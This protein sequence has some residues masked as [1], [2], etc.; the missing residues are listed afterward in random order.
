[1]RHIHTLVEVLNKII[2]IDKLQYNSFEFRDE[3]YRTAF[4]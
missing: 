4:Q 2:A 1:M 3:D